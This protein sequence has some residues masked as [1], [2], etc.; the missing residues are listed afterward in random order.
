MSRNSRSAVYYGV[1]AAVAYSY[2]DSMAE[3]SSSPRRVEARRLKVK[4]GRKIEKIQ[5][6]NFEFDKKVS[7]KKK[8]NKKK[9]SPKSKKRRSKSKQSKK[10]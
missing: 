3:T 2:T 8:S 9:T 6:M 4:L 5:K 7:K 10:R 1:A